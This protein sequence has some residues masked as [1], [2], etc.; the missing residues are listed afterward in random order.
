MREN[1]CIFWLRTILLYLKL[2]ESVGMFIQKTWLI[3]SG[4]GQ[5]MNKGGE[6]DD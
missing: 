4:L 2:K 1:S 3:F 6:D 5:D